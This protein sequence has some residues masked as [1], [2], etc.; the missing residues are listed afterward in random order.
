MNF[1]EVYD[2]FIADEAS[3]DLTDLGIEQFNKGNLDKAS[4]LFDKALETNPGNIRA[5]QYRAFCKWV[6]IAA[7]NKPDADTEYVQRYIQSMISDLETV[8]AA[9]RIFSEELNRR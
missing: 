1:Q 2:Y 4:L 8:L 3:E 6:L 9:I 7:L 5:L